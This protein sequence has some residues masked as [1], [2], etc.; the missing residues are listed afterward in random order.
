MIGFRFSDYFELDNIKATFDN[1]LKLFQE[2]LLYNN[3]DINNTLGWMTELDQH[4]N[5]TN[6]KYA[7]LILSMIWWQ[8]GMSIKMKT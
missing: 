4:Y 1:L 3:S 5:I 6:D 8:R 7:W 2:L